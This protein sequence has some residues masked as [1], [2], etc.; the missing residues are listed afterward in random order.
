[1]LQADQEQIQNKKIMRRIIF[2]TKAE[3]GRK[4]DLAVSDQLTQEHGREHHR[5]SM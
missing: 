3:D 1:M 5:L 2:E 4:H